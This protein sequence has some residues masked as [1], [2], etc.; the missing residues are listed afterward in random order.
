MELRIAFRAAWTPRVLSLSAHHGGAAGAAVRHS[1]DAE[2][3]DSSEDLNNMRDVSLPWFSRRPRTRRRRAAG[4]RPIHSL[5]SPSSCPG[6]MAFAYFIAPRAEGVLS[7]CFNGGRTRGICTASC[8]S[9]SPSRA[10]SAGA[11]TR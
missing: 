10:A 8:S 4:G 5:P 6:M 7:R 9:I 2:L 1:E 3:S 11:S